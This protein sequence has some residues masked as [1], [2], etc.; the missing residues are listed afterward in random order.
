M[1]SAIESQGEDV[2]KKIKAVFRFDIT[3][4][5]KVMKYWLVDLKNGSGKISEVD[6][7]TK[8]ECT[9]KLSDRNF[10]KLIRGKL[11][12]MMAYSSGQVKVKGNIMLAMKIQ[13]L[14][15]MVSVAS[16]RAKL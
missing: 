6:K 4:K 13:K 9:I 10:V 12:P 2:V 15:K 1:K 16:P 11:N 3:K 8:A 14:T 7:K 5:G